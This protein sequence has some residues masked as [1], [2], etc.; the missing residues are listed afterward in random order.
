MR[1]WRATVRPHWIEIALAVAVVWVAAV[2]GSAQVYIYIRQTDIMST[3]ATIAER[4]L[5]E[6][7]EDRRAWISPFALA[8]TI[9]ANVPVRLGVSVENS[10]KSPATNVVHKFEGHTID[11]PNG[12][13]ASATW[14]APQLPPNESCINGK[15]IEGTKIIWPST[16]T[17]YQEVLEVLTTPSEIPIVNALVAGAKTLYIQGCFSYIT[18]ER[19]RYSKYCFFLIPNADGKDHWGYAFCPTGN[20][21]N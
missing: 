2:V 15:I 17:G 16:A 8:P 18:V 13:H 19:P 5:S 4:Q 11:I 21:G 14:I 1:N 12:A 7:K 10:G 3:Q 9:S 20:D 6:M